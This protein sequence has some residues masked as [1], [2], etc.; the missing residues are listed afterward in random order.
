M[1][2]ACALIN[3]AAGLPSPLNYGEVLRDAGRGRTAKRRT[4]EKTIT[5]HNVQ[6]AS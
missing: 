6:L 2:V 5:Q 1:V 3:A 4:R